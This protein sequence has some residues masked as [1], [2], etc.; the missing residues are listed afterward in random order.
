MA[1]KTT[2]FALDRSIFEHWLWAEKPFDVLHAWVYLIGHANYADTKK[3]YKGKLQVIK[4]GQLVTSQ[5]KLAEDWG[6]SRAKV[7]NF[8]G[9][10]VEDQMI[11]LN[12]TTDCTTITV[13]NYGKFQDIQPTKRTT[14][15]TTQC[16]TDCTTER[17][18]NNK[19]NKENKENNI[20]SPSREEVRGYVSSMGFSFNA[21]EFC[22]T[23]EE[24]GW[25]D[26]KGQPIRNWRALCRK[27]N[28]TQ[29]VTYK[30]EPTAMEKIMAEI[31]AR[32]EAEE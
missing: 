1:D 14:D 27:W 13:E 28:S 20:S 26:A 17:T 4:R 2:F 23:Y 24:T 9:L 19:G 30:K 29:P 21:D 16:T 3:L 31:K 25:K 5:R 11:T 22:D 10:L 6:W 32:K 12:S 18:N 8:L 15:C 7:R